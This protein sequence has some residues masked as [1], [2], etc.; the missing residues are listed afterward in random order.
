M[1]C[2]RT[3]AIIKVLSRCILF[4]TVATKQCGYLDS[5]ELEGDKIKNVAP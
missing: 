5:N 3:G 2:R 4:D 1:V